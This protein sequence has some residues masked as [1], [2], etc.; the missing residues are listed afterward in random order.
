MDL[1]QV[2]T[3][4]ASENPQ[5]RMRGITALRDYEAAIAA[6]LLLDCHEDPEAIVR[7][8]VAMGLGYKQSPEALAVLREMVEH[9]ADPNVRGEACG[10]L[11]KYGRGQVP[12]LAELFR[13]DRHWL[14]RMSILLAV[15]DLDC[16]E[17]FLDLCRQ[18]LAESEEAVKSTA[19]EQLPS[20]VG[21][22]Q[23]SAALAFLLEFATA[24]SWQVRRVVAI[25][26]QCF[27]HPEARA[28]LQVLRQDP[29]HQVVAATLEVLLYDAP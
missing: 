12:L 10:A 7:S 4:L 14:L 24:K 9:D 19:L 22:P 18:A 20:L 29:V 21:T 23:E 17:T 16:P 1:S 15:A 28:A 26:L 8:F 3:C 11:G 6:P 27:E 5:D 2:K 13:R 25:A